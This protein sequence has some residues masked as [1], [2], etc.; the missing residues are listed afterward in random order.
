MATTEIPK[1]ANGSDSTWQSFN[2]SE[3]TTQSGGK[4]Y[5]RKVGNIVEIDADAVRLNEVHGGKTA[6]GTVPSGYRPDK[7]VYINIAANG[8]GPAQI[9]IT[10]GG[11]ISL[12]PYTNSW[13]TD[14]TIFVHVMYFSG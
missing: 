7:E 3:T 5:Y 13:P 2:S 12:Y 4:F 6:I 1:Y 8:L 10:T 9:G 14:K 11:V